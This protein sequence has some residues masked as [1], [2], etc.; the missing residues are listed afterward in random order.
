VGR[1]GGPRKGSRA[2][3]YYRCPA[4][5]LTLHSAA[6]RFSANVCP[7]CGAPLAAAD[8]VYVEE[9]HP[10]AITRRFP[11]ER[12]S[13]VTARREL[14]R[15]LWALDQGEFETLS[16]LISE[17]VANSI[18]HSGTR[19]GG[20]IRMDVVLTQ[21]VARVEVRDEGKG[22]A[23]ARR[24]PSSPLESN[25]GLHLLER[26]SDRWGVENGPHTLVWFELDRSG[27]TALHESQP[28]G[29]GERSRPPPRAVGESG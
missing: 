7:N 21:D 16:L 22:F 2:V 26:L 19:A 13:V 3:P 20:V 28:T 10:A 18:K 25:W 9:H 5:A 14:E 15:L 8:R 4:C 27:S 6:G 23:P 12:R 1:R 24:T 11:V 29:G 17:L